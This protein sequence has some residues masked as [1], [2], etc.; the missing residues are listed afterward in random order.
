MGTVL[1]IALS[2]QLRQ[3]NETIA[4]LEDQIFILKSAIGNDQLFPPSWRLS[5]HL[6][7]LLAFLMRSV[8]PTKQQCMSALYWDRPNDEPETKIIDVFLCRLRK[9]LKAVDATVEIETIWGG[10]IRMPQSSKDKL[11]S[12]LME[13]GLWREAPA[14]SASVL[15]AAQ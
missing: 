14:Q 10:S 15:E 12:L 4:E 7:R 11:K 6:Q 2:A 9:S 1:E 13:E 5:G 8:A 3:A